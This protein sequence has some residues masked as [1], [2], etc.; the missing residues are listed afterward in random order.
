[1]HSRCKDVRDDA[2]HDGAFIREVVREQLNSKRLGVANQQ[3]GE[4]MTRQV[5]L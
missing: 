2:L 4:P 5:V 3:T 1:M